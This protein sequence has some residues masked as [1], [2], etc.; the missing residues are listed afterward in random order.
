M[1]GTRIEDLFPQLERSNY[2]ITSPATPEYNCI[3]WAASDTEAWWEPDPFYLSFWPDGITREYSLDAYINAYKTV[4]Y[5]V[6]QSAEHEESYE[7]IAIYVDPDGK[8]THAARQL[9]SG[10]WTSKLGQLED[11]EHVTLES[12]TNSSYGSI[13]IIMKRLKNKSR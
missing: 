4:G 8:P 5:T 9:S 7:K 2:V 11:I 3:A 1:N 10:R 12:L 13:A 6:C